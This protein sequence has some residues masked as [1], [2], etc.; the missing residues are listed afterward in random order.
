MAPHPPL[1]PKD[2]GDRLTIQ[3]T[4]AKVG[5]FSD[6]YEGRLRGERGGANIAVAVKF[7]RSP[8]DLSPNELADFQRKFQRECRAW[9]DLDHPNILKFLGVATVDRHPGPT[10]VSPYC[11]NGTVMS[12]I[13]ARPDLIDRLSLVVGVAEGL[14]YLHENGVIHGDLKG[15]NVLIDDHGQPL[16]ADFGRSQIDG[17]NE[18]TRVPSHSH[19][20]TAPEILLLD[21]PEDQVSSDGFLPLT[22]TK[23]SDVYSLGMTALEIFSG[24]KPYFWKA[25]DPTVVIEL[26]QRNLPPSERYLNIDRP[27]WQVLSRLW[28]HQPEGRM[29]LGEALNQLK[30]ILRQRGAIHA[31]TS[32]SPQNIAP[33]SMGSNP[34]GR[35]TYVS[36][37]SPNQPAMGPSFHASPYSRSE[38]LQTNR[39]PMLNP[40]HIGVNLTTSDRQPYAVPMQQ[41]HATGYPELNSYPSPT[42]AIQSPQFSQ[43][44]LHPTAVIQPPHLS[45][46]RS[47]RPN[48]SLSVDPNLSLGTPSSQPGSGA[49]R[50]VGRS[51]LNPSPRSPPDGPERRDGRYEHRPYDHEISAGRERGS[52][53]PAGSSVSRSGREPPSEPSRPD[54]SRSMS[55][56][57]PPDPPRYSNRRDERNDRQSYDYPASTS[58]ESAPPAQASRRSS[59]RSRYNDPPPPQLSPSSAR[60]GPPPS[61]SSSSHV[62]YPVQSIQPDNSPQTIRGRSR[63]DSQSNQR[64]SDPLSFD[65]PAQE[66]RGRVLAISSDPR[67]R[68]NPPPSHRSPS[69]SMRPLLPRSELSSSHPSQP[70][71]SRLR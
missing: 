9:Q 34:S 47:G 42:S 11:K 41:S 60:P 49:T 68:Q 58:R 36:T 52:L 46:S 26:A 38:S 24:K 27:T 6:V 30:L 17:L 8:R 20:H 57:S 43:R 14:Y 1:P 37:P 31:T 59:S 12:Y 4:L 53:R 7:L 2:L 44:D 16:L 39:S 21:I 67:S 63:S 61:Q 69:Q 70:Y 55:Q 15:H 22:A 64:P 48:A 29:K 62:Q 51:P 54:L 32:M 45:T 18:F 23:K 5:G 35:T 50:D 3:P 19:R 56:P 28:V 33:S 25:N 71:A 40:L 66:S 10:F 13:A 65:P